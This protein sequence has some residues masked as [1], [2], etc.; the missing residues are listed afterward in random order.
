M[1]AARA[2]APQARLDAFDELRDQIIGG[3]LPAV[4]EELDDPW[5]RQASDGARL[6]LEAANRFR[7]IE[8][9]GV[10]HFQ[11]HPSLHVRIKAEVDDAE[12]ALS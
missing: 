10:Q 5:M 2:L 12:S 8:P 4:I 7:L 11:R 6:A 1:P 3:A 9:A